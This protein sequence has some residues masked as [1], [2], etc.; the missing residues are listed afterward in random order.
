ME[1]QDFTELQSEEFA[2]PQSMQ[3]MQCGISPRTHLRN[4]I[5]DH[6]RSVTA[7]HHRISSVTKNKLGNL[8]LRWLNN[9][10]F[11]ADQREIA[12]KSHQEQKSFYPILH[13]PHC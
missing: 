1:E 2:Q 12:T 13:I 9:N 3:S 6:P 4:L 7:S 10:V 8:D 5:D 11:S